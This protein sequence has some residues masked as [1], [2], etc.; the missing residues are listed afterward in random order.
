MKLIDFKQRK[1]YLFILKFINQEE[2][3]T[4]LEQLI[5]SYVS[6]DRLNTARLNTEWGCLEF[7]SGM[8]DIEPKTLYKYAGSHSLIHNNH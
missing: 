4:D 3:E 2:I 7:E 1:D 8:V 5:G 6:V